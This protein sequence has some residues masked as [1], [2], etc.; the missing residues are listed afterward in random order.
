MKH[1]DNLPVTWPRHADSSGFAEAC[2][3]INHLT[4][5]GSVVTKVRIRLGWAVR[6]P[7]RHGRSATI[8]ITG[9]P[10]RV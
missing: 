10:R 1:S 3:T 5:G 6:L 2:D 9:W 7:V 8:W 4:R